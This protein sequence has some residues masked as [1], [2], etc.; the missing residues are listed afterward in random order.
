MASNILTTPHTRVPPSVSLTTVPSEILHSI[1]SNLRQRDVYK[2]IRVCRRIYTVAYEHLLEDIAFGRAVDNWR[3]RGL[4]SD[5]WGLLAKRNSKIHNNASELPWNRTRTLA[6]LGTEPWK[7]PAL[8]D[9]LASKIEEGVVKLQH[10]EF[11]VLPAIIGGSTMP[12]SEIADKFFESLKSYANEK[13]INQFSYSLRGGSF[14]CHAKNYIILRNVTSIVY[15]NGYGGEYYP[16]RSTS[17]TFGGLINLLSATDNLRKL[18]L[19]A[20]GLLASVI[21]L[22]LRASM[23]SA[24]DNLRNLV[25]L[26]ISGQFFSGAAFFTPP[27]NVRTLEFHCEAGPLWWFGFS[28]CELPKVEKL[29]LNCYNSEYKYYKPH[30]RDNGGYGYI[31]YYERQGIFFDESGNFRIEDLAI[32]TLKDFSGDVNPSGPL[33]LLELLLERNPGLSKKST[34]R[35]FRQIVHPK[36]LVSL[37]RM[38]Q[39]MIE[40]AGLLTEEYI[41]KWE[42]GARGEDLEKEYLKRGLE[43]LMDEVLDDKFKEW[44]ME[45]SKFTRK[46]R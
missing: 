12:N 34:N 21:D 35:M 41:S 23:Q 15:D 18:S 31:R 27:P 17:G 39:R 8:M 4:H 24:F 40:H 9:M 22:E 19:C 7:D 33:N 1:I 11:D 43:I 29:V 16:P 5:Q 10:V 32:T 14:L 42:G 37:S 26:K 30:L 28:R 6:I 44:P 13:S 2:L 20:K 36:L 38:E 25:E 46:G 45:R 3:E